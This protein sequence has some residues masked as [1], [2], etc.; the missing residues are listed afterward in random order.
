MRI[1]IDS[2]SPPNSV[3]VDDEDESLQTL[4][5]REGRVHQSVLSC[6]QS[7]Q[8]SVSLFFLTDTNVING[9]SFRLA[10]LIYSSLTRVQSI[11]LFYCGKTRMVLRYDRSHS[12]I[13]VGIDASKR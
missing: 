11:P 1:N 7:Q 4:G 13:R 3:Q 2:L 8:V 10:E 12:S 5:E 9:V 6:H